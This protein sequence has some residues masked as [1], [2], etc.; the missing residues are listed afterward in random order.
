MPPCIAC[1]ASPLVIPS[2][3]I[4]ARA[5]GLY[6]A[7]LTVRPASEYGSS[8]P[9]PTSCGQNAATTATAGNVAASRA[10]TV[11][12]IP[13]VVS[14]ALRMAG[15]SPLHTAATS[16]G[17]RIFLRV[18]PQNLVA[19][20]S[21]GTVSKV[22]PQVGRSEHEPAR[23]GAATLATMRRASVLLG[24]LIALVLQACGSIRSAPS[25]LPR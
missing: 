13:I 23:V 8:S 20:P 18:N 1:S 24:F 12:G 5:Y 22:P 17:A 11:R 3:C 6:V 14:G 7:W 25:D 21:A 10:I 9:P 16:V 4:A 2:S 15:A 19:R